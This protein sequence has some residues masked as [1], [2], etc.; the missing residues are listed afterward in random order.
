MFKRTLLSL[1]LAAPVAAHAVD[2][3][4]ELGQCRYGLAANGTFYES[5]PGLDYRN[6]MT[7][8]CGAVGLAGA[9]GASSFGWRVGYL[10]TGTIQ[11]RDN[12][13]RFGDDANRQACDPVTT[14]GC[15]ASFNGS[16]YS[17]GVTLS[18]TDTHKWSQRVSTTNEA[19]V[20]FFRHRFH[21]T[22]TGQ[23][24]PGVWHADEQ[25]R[26]TDAPSPYLGLIVRYGPVY[27]SIRH[28]FPMGHRALSLTDFSMTSHSI[29]VEVKAW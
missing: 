15:R 10:R 8:R 22:A 11:A 3:Y 27:Y 19:G 25:S 6:Y 23:E 4:A 26:I 2:L 5:D 28:Y 13:A 17:E 16:G 1:A 9:F 20:F 14:V 29:G 18:L 21:A 24:I 7:P 12:V